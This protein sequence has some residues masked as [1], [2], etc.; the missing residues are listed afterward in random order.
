MTHHVPTKTGYDLWAAAYD[1]NGN[2][3][4]ALDEAELASLLAPDLAG[5]TALDLGCGTGRAT[6]LMALRGARVTGLD[7]SPG[8]L[9]VAREKLARLPLAAPVTL[10]EH[11]VQQPLP[12]DNASF[13][14]VTSC[15]VLE[16]I[17]DLRSFFAEIA[18][19]ARPEAMIYVSAMHPALLL[20]GVQANFTDPA[21]GDE[22][23]P[24]GYP[25]TLADFINAIVATDLGLRALHEE[26]PDASF[27]V[28]YPKAEK[29]LGWPMLAAFQLAARRL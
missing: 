12:F 11:D 16:H 2:P 15:L 21:S 17:S 14:L 10:L 6:A 24:H 20:R 23:R 19:V 22:I 8:M 5:K 28:R 13:D 1:T 26:S 29:Y 18:R 25:H 4:V 7:F 3:L 27:I 9:D